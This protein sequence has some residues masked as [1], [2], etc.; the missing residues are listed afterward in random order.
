MNKLKVSFI[1]VFAFLINFIF[2]T[3][4]AV[5]PLSVFDTEG[6]SITITE[7]PSVII[8]NNLEQTW[9]EGLI[10]FIQIPENSYGIP[11]TV[12]D[13]N[14]ICVTENKD[15]LLYGYIKNN[16]TNWYADIKLYCAQDKKIAQEYFASDDVTH[17]ERLIKE[18]TDKILSGI[19]ELSGINPETINNSKFRPAE[20][21]IPLSAFYWTPIDN[22]WNDKILGIAGAATGLD[23]FPPIPKSTIRELKLDFSGSLN[24]SWQYAINQ[25]KTYPFFLNTISLI[26]PFYTHLY[27]NERNSIYAGIGLGYEIELINIRPKYE[28][29]QFIY[30]NIFSLETSIGYEFMIN[31]LLNFHTGV[32][33]NFHL[34][35]DKRISV[36]PHIGLSFRVF[37]EKS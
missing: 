28:P 23:F 12:I 7:N 29:E 19:G 32:A 3:E 21:R 14:K 6:N 20:L 5:A 35:P 11:S 2:A 36:K 4:I 26:F 31:N 34:I 33:F 1:I 8:Y 22:K 30:Q 15:Y 10:H 17:Y 27:F 25:Q 24:I 9:F 13:A 18:L 16:E 37:K